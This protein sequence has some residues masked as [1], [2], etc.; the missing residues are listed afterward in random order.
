MHI[1]ITFC[2]IAPHPDPLFKFHLHEYPTGIAGRQL[3]EG[4]Q[5][6]IGRLIDVLGALQIAAIV[7]ML[8]DLGP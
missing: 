3:L 1:N 4:I 6:G 8:P 5:M 7:Q 2:N